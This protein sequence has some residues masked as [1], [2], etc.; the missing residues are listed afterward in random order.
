MEHIDEENDGEEYVMLIAK[1]GKRI[2]EFY[3]FHKKC[4]LGHFKEYYERV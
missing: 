3:I 4:W 1:K 2:R